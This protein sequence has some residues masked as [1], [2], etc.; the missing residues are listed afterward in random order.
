M[1]TDLS[2][3]LNIVKNLEETHKNKY[4]G[5]CCNAIKKN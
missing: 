2:K 4:K 3:K 1:L 5:I